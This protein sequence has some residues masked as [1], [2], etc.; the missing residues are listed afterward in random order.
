M[1]ELFEFLKELGKLCA[2]LCFWLFIAVLGVSLIA[3]VLFL[4]AGFVLGPVWLG[5]LLGVA[6]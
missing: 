4:V 3:A 5:I 2:F 1:K 6:A